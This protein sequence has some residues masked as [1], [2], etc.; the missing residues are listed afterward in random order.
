MGLP[1]VK[2]TIGTS[3]LDGGELPMDG[4]ENSNSTTFTT[5]GSMNYEDSPFTLRLEGLLFPEEDTG[6]LSD[7]LPS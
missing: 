6:S 4:N 5:R 1:L 3:T 7:L 2:A